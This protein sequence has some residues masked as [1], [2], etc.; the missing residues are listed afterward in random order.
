MTNYRYHVNWART[1]GDAK[2]VHR[3]WSEQTVAWL[4]TAATYA[5]HIH[6]MGYVW[7]ANSYTHQNCENLNYSKY[8]SLLLFL[9]SKV[10]T[11]ARPS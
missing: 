2:R 1:V 11:I 6:N 3:T 10:S 8:C 5:V 4:S 9:F 7:V